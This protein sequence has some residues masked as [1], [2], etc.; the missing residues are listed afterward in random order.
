LL[1]AILTAVRNGYKKFVVPEDN[2]DELVYI[3][4]IDLFVASSIQQLVSFVTGD[5]V[6]VAHVANK[7]LQD[8]YVASMDTSFDF[9]YIK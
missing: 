1:P 2:V 6:L 5:Q 8:L 3:P 7:S 4:D 9:G